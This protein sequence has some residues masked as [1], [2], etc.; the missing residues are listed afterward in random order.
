MPPSLART[1]RGV[2]PVRSPDVPARGRDVDRPLAVAGD[3][4]QAE[5][6]REETRPGSV[7]RV[8]AWRHARR[9]ERAHQCQ[10]AACGALQQHDATS[11][12][13]TRMDDSNTV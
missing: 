3:Q 10:A 9:H 13:T 6:G 2:T 5:R 4:R 1:P 8:S 11:A 7:A 12:I